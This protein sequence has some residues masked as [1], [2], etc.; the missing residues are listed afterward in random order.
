MKYGQDLLDKLKSS[1]EKSDVKRVADATEGAY[2]GAAIGALTGL[3]IGYQR[4]QNLIMSAFIGAAVGGLISKIVI[5]K[6]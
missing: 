4:K 6:K 3:F 2:V 1:R 5:S